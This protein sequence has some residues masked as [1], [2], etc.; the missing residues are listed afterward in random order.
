MSD[1]DPLAGADI[2][3]SETVT[4]EKEFHGINYEPHEFYGSDR[5]ADPSIVDVEVEHNEDGADDFT[6]IWEGEVTKQ[7]PRNW[8]HHREPITETE[9]RQERRQAWLTRVGRAAQ[10]IIPIGL[11]TLIAAEVMNTIMG[12]VTMNGESVGAPGPWTIAL[13]FAVMVVLA[14]GVQQL[15]RMVQG[16]R[17]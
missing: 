2:G 15:P 17:A 6:I 4:V 11:C 10:I 16:G 13:V 5:F 1:S 3:E 8:D 14:F 9:Q 7:L 12:E